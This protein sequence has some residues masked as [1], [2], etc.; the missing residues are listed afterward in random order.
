ML[1]N[2]A[3]YQNNYSFW[4]YWPL[5]VEGELSQTAASPG[6]Y[7]GH[8]N[9]IYEEV[10]QN[11]IASSYFGIVRKFKQKVKQSSFESINLMNKNL[12]TRIGDVVMRLIDL[13][14]D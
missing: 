7:F 13:S 5:T 9:I 4:S 12:V 10:S 8:S 2:L 14:S 11:I 1:F 6:K 3:G